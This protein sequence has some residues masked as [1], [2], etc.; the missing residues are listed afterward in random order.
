M[1]PE[2]SIILKCISDNSMV[3]IL[4]HNVSVD[5]FNEFNFEWEFLNRVYLEHG[6]TPSLD[7]FK[8]QFP[9][10][11]IVEVSDPLGY[12]VEELKTSYVHSLVVDSMRTQAEAL[13]R[14]DPY[15]A[16]NEMRK[17]ISLGEERMRT[18][19]DI[20]VASNP[21]SRIQDYREIERL[22]GMIGLPSP[23]K[24]LDELTQGFQD[25]DL[26]MIAARAG[27]GK[28]W[29]EVIIAEFLRR[30][31][32]VGVLFSKEMSVKQILRRF[33]AVTAGLP[34]QKFKS[35]SLTTMQ[36]EKYKE[37]MMALK[38]G[39]PLW[40]SGDIDTK[41]GVSSV[42][43]K[44][45]K[46]NPDMVYIDGVYMMRDERNAKQSWEK[47]SNICEDLKNLCQKKRTPILVTHQFNLSG[48][49]DQ[50]DADTL[51]YGDVQMWFDI[52][53][54]MYQTDDMKA[55]KEMLFKIN[56]CRDAPRIDWV[57]NWDL[58][59]MDF[60]LKVSGVDDIGDNDNDGDEED[61]EDES[62]PF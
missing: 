55:S 17:A 56:K 9:K 20:N 13:K 23:W 58:D 54:G 1:N 15:S 30:M 49:G 8:T 60:E 42:A 44:I 45:D 32:K 36:F 24:V 4:E 14:K 62:V 35:G 18:S 40:I 48:K 59:N 33:D 31:G 51:K 7:A 28:T 41:M 16:L 47:F 22:E 61:Y 39:T 10:F 43:S 38:G 25:E 12:I 27:L 52:M 21:E 53:I 34:Y 19:R 2:V 5:M 50:G 6:A 46:Y 57:T 3:D 29:C 37:T 26:I 11:P